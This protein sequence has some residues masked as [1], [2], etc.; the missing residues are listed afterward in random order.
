MCYNILRKWGKCMK[1]MQ[2]YEDKT[3]N[4]RDILNSVSSRWSRDQKIRFLYKNLAS[5][6][7]RDLHYF[8]QDDEEKK[9]QF[10]SGFVDRF[11]GVVCYTLAEFYCTVYREFGFEANIVQANS[12][13]IPLFGVVVRGDLGYY[14]LNPLEDLFLNQYGLMPQAF[15]YVPSFNTLNT[16]Y[17]N[18]VSLSKEYISTLDKSLGF[19]YL[20]DYFN[21]L[22]PKMKN[23]NEA[24]SFL[25]IEAPINKDIREQKLQFFSNNLINKGNVNGLFERA[26]LYLFLND[27][28]LNRREKRYVKHLIEDGLSD[29]PYI[30]YM[31]LRNDGIIT[32]REEKTPNGYV[33]TKHR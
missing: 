28:L 8:L 1:K 27:T 12:A 32:Y 16:S 10:S 23:L 17:P 14:F 33:L 18:L 21:E 3:T 7:Y 2:Y 6:V 9:R 19:T 26:Q 20:D 11:P 22:K 30:S 24:C 13:A 25:G 15:G 29:D 4:L 31:I 5:F